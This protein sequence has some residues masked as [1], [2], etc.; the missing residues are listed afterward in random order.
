MVLD[1]ATEARLMTLEIARGAQGHE[2]AAEWAADRL[3]RDRR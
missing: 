2:Q 1:D 3:K